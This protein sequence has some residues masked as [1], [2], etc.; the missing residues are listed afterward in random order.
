MPRAP[1]PQVRFSQAIFDRICDMIADGKSVR[2]ACAGKGMPDRATFNRWR[3]STPELQ[4]QYD[5]A[6]IEREEVYFE[7]IVDIADECRVGVKKTTKANG[8]VETVEIDMVERARVQIDARKWTLARMNRKKYGD[9][10]TE[11]L[12][13]PNGGPLQIE[14]VR[15]RM[16]PVEELPE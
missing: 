7:Q 5:A 8:D 16:T 14:R 1:A 4:A 6:C 12:T 9:H 10:V 11:E 13:G 15:L 3:K 2:Q